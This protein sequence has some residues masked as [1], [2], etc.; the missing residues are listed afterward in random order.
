MDDTNGSAHIVRFSPFE[1]DFRAGELRKNGLRVRLQEQ[2]FRILQLLLERPGELV[3]RE[4]LRQRLWP[5]DVF[6]AVDQSLNNAIKK[7]RAALG[8]PAENPRFIE[9]VARHGYRFIAPV[10]PASVVAPAVPLRRSLPSV[11]IAVVSLCALALVAY[12]LVDRP[13]R[14]VRPATDRVALAVLPFE[15]LSGDSSQEYFSDGL[16]E[17]MTTQL[18]TV[19]PRGLGVLA[20]TSAM[21]YKHTAKGA[22][23][24]G[25]ELR[26]DFL[27]E[28]SVR[29][30]NQRIRISAQLIR[31]SDQ[32]HVWA[33][34][35]E[36]DLREILVLQREVAQDIATHI[37]VSVNPTA[38]PQRC[39]G[40]VGSVR[41]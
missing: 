27:V 38:S 20:R 37:N 29:R 11:W 2:P 4:V 24:I 31:V 21:R 33:R 10:D 17:E 32:T 3:T 1:A 41:V 36:R 14:G 22:G 18:S 12:V 6:V 8:D 35:Y 34:S 9:T 30:E 16:T 39:R 19:N 5:A 15:N 40:D 23:E 28:G 13:A 26:V 7:L 25:K